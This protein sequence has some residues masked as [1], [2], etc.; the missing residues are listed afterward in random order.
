MYEGD[1]RSVGNHI[2]KWLTL[3]GGADLTA[4]AAVLVAVGGGRT[5]MILDALD[6]MALDLVYYRN[7]SDV[8]LIQ[9][10]VLS[11]GKEGQCEAGIRCAQCAVIRDG[12]SGGPNQ[13]TVAEKAVH[14]GGHRCHND[15]KG[16]GVGGACR[17]DQPVEQP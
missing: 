13:N 6:L 12:D 11:L 1:D 14:Q 5:A 3:E 10:F 2:L 7:H 9:Y 17:K 16:P 8:V 15:Y 4:V